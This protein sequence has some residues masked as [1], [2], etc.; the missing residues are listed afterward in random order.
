[1]KAIRYLAVCTGF[2]LLLASGWSSSARAQGPSA[3]VS[4]FATGLNNPS[5]LLKNPNLRRFSPAPNSSAAFNPRSASKPLCMEGGWIVNNY[6]FPWIAPSCKWL[7][8]Q[9]ITGGQPIFDAEAPGTYT[10]PE[11]V[12]SA[13]QAKATLPYFIVQRKRT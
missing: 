10:F 5:K 12:E 3:N 4:V 1:M 6:D 9:K 13:G 8:I 2:A 11:L 7:L